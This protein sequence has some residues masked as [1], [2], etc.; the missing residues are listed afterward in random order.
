MFSPRGSGISLARCDNLWP[1]RQVAEE[2]QNDHEWA[3]E[4]GSRREC[5]LPLFVPCPNRYNAIGD[6]GRDKFA[7][8]T[9]STSDGA[10]GALVLKELAFL[11]RL[12]GTAVRPSAYK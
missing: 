6:V 1:H 2:L 12:L 3:A 11:G 7:L 8:A 9:A 5:L 10:G 4:E